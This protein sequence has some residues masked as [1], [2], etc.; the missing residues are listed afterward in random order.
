[1]L[2]HQVLKVGGRGNVKEERI[3]ICGQEGVG[4]IVLYPVESVQTVD[5]LGGVLRVLDGEVTEEIHAA[6][7][8]RI[9]L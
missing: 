6:H 2:G 9:L 8:L 1:M 7:L 3:V 4:Q 5:D